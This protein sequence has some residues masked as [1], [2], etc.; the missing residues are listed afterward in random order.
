MEECQNKDRCEVEKMTIADGMH[1]IV[2]NINEARSAR[3]SDI[4][5]IR[6]GVQKDLKQFG[7]VRRHNATAQHKALRHDTQEMLGGFSADRSQLTKDVTNLRLDAIH[8]MHGIAD[9]RLA[10]EIEQSR[11]LKSY[12]DERLANGIEQS[13]TLKS[14]H[15]ERVTNGIELSRTLKSYHDGIMQDVQ[16]LRGPV[17]EDLAEAHAIWQSHVSGGHVHTKAPKRTEA[18]PAEATKTPEVTQTPEEK[19]DA[20]LKQKILKVIKAAPEGIT[21]AKAGKKVGV[22]WRRLIRP[23]KELVEAGLVAKKETQYFPS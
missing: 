15:D 21:L 1:Q 11:T 19:A 8:M 14:Y 23:A 3:V 2:D 7:R 6:V 16:Q 12:H 22:E 20:A 18:K 17:Q 13:R 5:S 9:E 4:R 10:N